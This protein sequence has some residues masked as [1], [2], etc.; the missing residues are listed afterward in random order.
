ME[1]LVQW[2]DGASLET[3]SMIGAGTER[4]GKLYASDLQGGDL[5]VVNHDP[6]IR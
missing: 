5:H 3:A 2:N 6:L 4:G 1:N